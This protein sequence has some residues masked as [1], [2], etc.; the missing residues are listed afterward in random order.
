MSAESWGREYQPVFLRGKYEKEDKERSNV[1]EK[2]GT[3]KIRGN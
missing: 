3:G 1:K 2:G